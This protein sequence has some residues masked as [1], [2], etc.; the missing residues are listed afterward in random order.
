[1]GDYAVNFAIRLFLGVAKTIDIK[2][3]VLNKSLLVRCRVSNGVDQQAAQ[4]PSAA[5]Q[6]SD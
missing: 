1:M 6:L 4:P 5:Y 2:A 3:G